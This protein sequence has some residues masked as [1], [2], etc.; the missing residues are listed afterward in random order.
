MTAQQG[1]DRAKVMA[2]MGKVTADSASAMATVMVGIGDRLGLF[3]ALAK[4]P[5][6]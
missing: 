3:K 1:I 4:A 6:P 5:A 2:F